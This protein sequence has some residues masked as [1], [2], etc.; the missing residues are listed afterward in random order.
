MH[1]H[2]FILHSEH[3]I[4][5]PLFNI[6]FEQ[7]LPASHSIILLISIVYPCVETSPSYCLLVLS[8]LRVKGKQSLI[9]HEISIR[10]D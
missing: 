9:T 3:Y 8:C 4:S 6:P 10:A 2:K 7:L 1:L 5:D